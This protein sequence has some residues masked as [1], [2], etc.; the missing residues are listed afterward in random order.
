VFIIFVQGI[1]R[2]GQLIPSRQQHTLIDSHDRD[3]GLFWRLEILELERNRNC[4]S[5]VIRG[6][7]RSHLQIQIFLVR[8]DI[9]F[10]LARLDQRIGRELPLLFLRH[11]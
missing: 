1:Q 5:R 4:V 6:T 8:L 2:V 10:Y 7:I 11:K 9:E 3:F